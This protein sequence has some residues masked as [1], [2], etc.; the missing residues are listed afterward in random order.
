VPLQ[1]R[2]LTDLWGCL[3]SVA[4]RSRKVILLFWG[5]AV[6]AGLS[7]LLLMLLSS[8][9]GLSWQGQGCVG[10]DGGG[11]RGCRRGLDPG[12]TQ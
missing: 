4:S 7:W 6:K 10:Q 2:K 5:S 3:R 12:Q 11:S 9:P 8:V 1:Q